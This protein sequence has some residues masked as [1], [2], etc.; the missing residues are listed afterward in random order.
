LLVVNRLQVQIPS[1]SL[2]SL[3]SCCLTLANESMKISSQPATYPAMSYRDKMQC[4][5]VIYT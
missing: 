3:G 2:S 5:Q 4:T 1:D